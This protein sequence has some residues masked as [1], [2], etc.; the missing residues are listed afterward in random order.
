MHILALE[1]YYG[2]SHKAFLDGWR[3][4]SRHQFTLLTLPAYKWKWRMRHAP[5]SF[6]GQ[7]AGVS[8]KERD[9]QILWCSDMLSLADFV[10]LA[11]SD[12]RD[13]PRIAYFH[14]NQWTYPTGRPDPRD[15]HFGFSNLTTALSADQVWF[16]SAFH[17]D[18]FLTAAEKFIKKMP[19]FRPLDEIHR[20]RQKSIISHPGISIP[21]ESAPRKSGPLRILWAARWE[22]D[23]GPETF[24][25][26]IAAL[27]DRDLPFRLSVI[28]QTFDHT[29]KV[30]SESRRKLA[31]Y[32]DHWGY[33]K[34]HDDYVQCIRDADVFVSTAAHEFFGLSAAESI[35]AGC[36][37]ILPQRLAYPELLDL[38]N[39]RSHQDFFYD[40]TTT[41]LIDKL[42]ELIRWHAQGVDLAS[43]AATARELMQRFAWSHIVDRMDGR[44][45]HLGC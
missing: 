42:A 8:E 4:R 45:E 13:L 17:R 32:I 20:I 21:P 15:Q 12:I 38:A 14:E 31:S 30:F 25:E 40:G 27:A 35:A 37:P 6:S 5:V 36:Y 9:W 1:P 16:N 26:A 11:T 39:Q 2:G 3:Q 41:A 18:D 23:K 19:D 33:Q 44:I 28:G 7:L 24:F 22:H 29:P 43:R 34:S 10:G